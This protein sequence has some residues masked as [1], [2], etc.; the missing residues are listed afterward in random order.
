[1]LLLACD[2][3]G[4]TDGG[5]TLVVDTGTSRSTTDREEPR[6][7]RQ[8]TADDVATSTPDGATPNDGE[9]VSADAGDGEPADAGDGVSADA[10]DG[11]SA[12][13]GDRKPAESGF[14]ILGDSNSDEYRADD[15]RGGAYASVTFNWM[16]LLVKARSL[17]FGAWGTWG[18]ARRT[19]FEHNWAR[20]GARADDLVGQGQAAGVAQQITSGAVEYVYVHIGTNDFHLVN[21]TYREI[22]DGTL[23]DRQVAAKVAKVAGDVTEAIDIVL[24]ARPERIIL[25]LFGDPGLTPRALDAYPSAAGRDR[26][27]MA[28]AAVN[29]QLTEMAAT[30]P[31]VSL[32]DL[33]AF[34]TDLLSRVDEGGNLHVGGELISTVESGDEPHH[35]QLGGR[36]GHLGTVM[37]GL[38]ANATFIGPFNEVEQLD[39]P[40]LTDEEILSY[41]GL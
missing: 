32:Y 16:E 5:S 15:N 27:S 2:G 18:G 39:I 37:S 26:V 24:A 40:M 1:M 3:T 13:A 11:V 35:A 31:R 30:R 29:Q 38:F 14:A 23:T 19:G 17:D 28:I 4:P 34:A 41:A 7:Q 6:V 9:H 8:E 25:T 10:G 20:S 22:Y 33:N 36:R 12:D 21:G